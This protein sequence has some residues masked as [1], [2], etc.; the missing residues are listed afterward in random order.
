LRNADLSTLD[1]VINFILKIT[2]GNDEFPVT[3]PEE[4]EAVAKL[5]VTDSKAYE[6]VWNHTLEI[7]RISSSD[8][9]HILGKGKYEQVNEDLTSGLSITKAIIDGTSTGD[10]SW[11]IKGMKETID[12]ARRQVTKW[13]YKEFR[14][15]SAAMG[16]DVIPSVRWNEEVLKDEILYKNIIAQ[17]VD[18]RMLSYET[19][20][21]SLGYN[22]DVE[23]SQM[24]SELPLVEEGIFGIHG[25]PF[26]QTSQNTQEAPSGTPSNG[27]PTGQ[28][29]TKTPETDPNNLQDNKASVD[30]IVASIRD[31]S[32]TE[33]QQL[34]DILRD[35]HEK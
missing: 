13:I 1:G 15:V 4:L 7:E 27:R 30:I 21:E 31:M 2:V 32:S 29:N 35:N 34:I 28:T 20:L 23:K 10:P 8:V 9:E 12:Y 22:F 11:A 19:A 3:S 6:I 25:S 26:Q 14:L 5:F 18:R 16:F 24:E 17:L 33:K